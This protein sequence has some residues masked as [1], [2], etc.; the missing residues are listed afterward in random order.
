M[1][2]THKYFKQA[3]T[4]CFVMQGSEVVIVSFTWRNKLSASTCRPM[5]AKQSAV[6]PCSFTIIAVGM[7]GRPSRP[8]CHT[9]PWGSRSGGSLSSG[10]NRRGAWA[11]QKKPKKQWCSRK[12]KANSETNKH[13][14]TSSCTSLRN[15][16]TLW[17]PF[18]FLLPSSASFSSRLRWPWC[19]PMPRGSCNSAA[20]T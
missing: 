9:D 17:R 11:F 2:K 8:S 3:L 12:T 20:P 15:A 4:T 19:M 16:A 13:Q 5:A 7:L 6:A 18:A 10:A 14:H 1:I